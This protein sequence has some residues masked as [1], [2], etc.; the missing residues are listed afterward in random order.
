MPRGGDD[1]LAYVGYYGEVAD[2]DGQ[3]AMYARPIFVDLPDELT[4]KVPHGRSGMNGSTV[5]NNHRCVLR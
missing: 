1:A 4:G 5:T 3:H 2:K